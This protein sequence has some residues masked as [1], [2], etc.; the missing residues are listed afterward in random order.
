MANGQRKTAPNGS[1]PMNVVAVRVRQAREFYPG[2]LTQDREATDDWTAPVREGAAS[3]RLAHRLFSIPARIW[4]RSRFGRRLWS[5]NNL[6]RGLRAS[7]GGLASGESSIVVSTTHSSHNSSPVDGRGT[8]EIRFGHSPRA[9][10][11]FMSGFSIP[12][13]DLSAK[14]N[15]SF[16]GLAGVLPF[17]FGKAAA[18]TVPIFPFASLAHDIPG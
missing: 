12:L 9:L 4:E 5:E 15:P 11:G 18:A 6:S 10:T 7:A 1:T 3:P 16:A 13:L 17:P 14:R 8:G 2:R